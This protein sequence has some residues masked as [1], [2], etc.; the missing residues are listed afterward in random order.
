VGIL[1]LAIAAVVVFS[2]FLAKSNDA[3]GIAPGGMLAPFA[4][5]L[6]LGGLQGEANIATRPHQG[7]AGNVPACKVRGPQ[8]L[9]VCEL[10]ERGPVVLALFVDGSSC[11]Q[12]LGRMQAL[13]QSFPGVSFAAVAIGSSR[14]RVRELVHKRRLTIPV[15]LDEDGAL[16]TLYKV[17]SCPQVNFAY[18]GGV[19]QSKALLGTPSLA[20]LRA[21]V[22]ALVAA[23]RARGWR[24]SSV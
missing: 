15:G 22:S 1:G 7:A 24:G 23:S 14:S 16:A 19:V 11:P 17:F 12:V 5:P 20:G 3:S 4:A 10:Y 18:P 8:I 9:N 6:A 2:T 21:R 13:A